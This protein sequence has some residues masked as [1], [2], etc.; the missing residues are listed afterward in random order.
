MSH[1]NEVRQILM[2][3]FGLTRESIREEAS[4]IIR[5]TMEHHMKNMEHQ[6]VLQAIVEREFRAIVKGRGSEYQDSIKGM[7]L[8]AIE[9]SVKKYIGNLRVHLS[10]FNE[11]EKAEV[12]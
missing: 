1:N 11:S 12:E 2:N 3:E 6:G 7:C 9:A 4:K 10:G 8:A 5:E